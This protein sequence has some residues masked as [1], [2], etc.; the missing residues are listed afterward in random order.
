VKLA[1]RISKVQPSPTLAISAKAQAMAAEGIDVVSF[2]AGEPDFPT[3]SII[4]EAAKAALDAGHTG[5]I[6][7]DGLPALRKAIAADYARR[8]RH[9]DASEVIV[10]TGG[11]QALFNATFAL[12]EAGDKVIV[13]APYWVSYPAQVLLADAEPVMPLAG[14]ETDFKMTPEQLREELKDSAIRGLI[15]CSPSNPT[16][17]V[18]T[19]EE[20]R[21]I[22]DVLMEYPDVFIYFDAIYDRLCYEAEFAADFVTVNPELNSRT[23]TFN[24]FSKAYS[25]TGWR[26]GYSIAPAPITKA[27]SKLQSQSTS[28]ATTFAQYGALEA[29][30]LPDTEIAAMRDIFKRRRD[31]IV[32]AL[33]AIDGVRCPNPGGAFYVFPDFSEF[34]GEGKRFADDLALGAFLLDEARVA[35]V[36]GSAFGAPGHLRLSYATSDAIIKEGIERIARALV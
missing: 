1:S 20:L 31:W 14:I 18:Y 13:P 7:S 12:F 4:R 9:V 35:V 24:G 17:S 6:A 16:G 32:D 23:I 33:N 10:T 15:L 5:Y 25:M 28:N 3:P 11:K 30:K 19:A 36:P 29:L 21:A 26:L 34:C 22:G 27:M 8:G 2:G